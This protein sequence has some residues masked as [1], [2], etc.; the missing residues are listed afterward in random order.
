MQWVSEGPILES[1]PGSFNVVVLL[2]ARPISIRTGQ[3][4]LRVPGVRA[5]GRLERECCQRKANDVR[6]ESR[7]ERGWYSLGVV[8]VAADSQRGGD[9]LSARV[10]EVQC[11]T[12]GKV[13]RFRQTVGENRVSHVSTVWSRPALAHWRQGRARCSRMDA[14]VT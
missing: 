1:L 3:P 10:P 9:G 2:S 11:R 8:V 4:R 6:F 5:E 13:V 12:A 7:E 14:S